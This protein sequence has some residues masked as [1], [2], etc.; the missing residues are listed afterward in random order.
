MA[1]QELSWLPE[2]LAPEQQ[3]G[4]KLSEQL[5]EVSL[6]GTEETTPSDGHER[7]AGSTVGISLYWELGIPI[8]KSGCIK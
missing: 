2:I 7:G 8:M 6:Q 3:P 5:V 4:Q 1:P